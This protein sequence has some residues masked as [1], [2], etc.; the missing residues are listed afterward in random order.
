MDR[1]TVIEG[2]FDFFTFAGI[3]ESGHIS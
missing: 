2:V 3:E 1:A